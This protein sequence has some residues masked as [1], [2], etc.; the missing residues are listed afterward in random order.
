MIL[1]LRELER[2]VLVFTVQVGQKLEIRN[3]DPMMHNVHSYPGRNRPFNRPMAKGAA[4]FV[5][6]F[7]RAE[8]KSADLLV[9]VYLRGRVV[10]E[11]EIRFNAGDRERIDFDLG[12]IDLEPEV[13][14]SELE[15]LEAAIA[16][17]LDGVAYATFT[18]R[19]ILF[20]AHEAV[21]ADDTGPDLDALKLQLECLRAAAENARTTGI[22]LSAFYGW[23]RIFEGSPQTRPRK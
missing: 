20:L 11:S 3:S 19:E 15:A 6:K 4:P 13:P 5:T 7:R 14:I 17:V 16:P 22:P 1:S 18:D 23:F 8:K 10:A 2:N 12:D 9:R 21:R